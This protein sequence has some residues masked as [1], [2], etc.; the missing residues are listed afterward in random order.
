AGA[1]G[2]AVRA[3]ADAPVPTT[4]PP[5]VSAA[6]PGPASAGPT[7]T[8]AQA[9]PADAAGTGTSGPGSAGKAGG[10]AK[11]TTAPQRPAVQPLNASRPVAMRVERVGIDGPIVTLGRQAN[12]AMETPSDPDD[13]GWYTGSPQPGVLGPSVLAGHVTW[14][15]RE[16]VFFR[17]GDVRAGDE[18]EVDRADGSTAVF[19]V[20]KVETYPKDEFPTVSVYSN[21]ETAAL[22]LITCGGEYDPKKRYYASNVVVYADL[23]GHKA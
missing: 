18:I 4:P 6:Q 2:L 1:I 12:G 5:A 13:V 14:N 10:G 21:T 19:R 16:T 23:A 11:A 15:G 22:R 9:T 8:S 3:G 7:P 20:T 17:L